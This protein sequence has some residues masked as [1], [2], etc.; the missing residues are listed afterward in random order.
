MIDMF[1]DFVEVLWVATIGL[2]AMVGVLAV[3][4][5]V[6]WSLWWLFTQFWG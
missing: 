4:G 3:W 1:L 2:L 5:T 6:G